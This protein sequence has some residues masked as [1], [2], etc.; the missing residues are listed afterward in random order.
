MSRDSLHTGNGQELAEDSVRTHHAGIPCEGCGAFF[1]PSRP[2][3]RHCRPA[4]RPRA[5]RRR[6]ADRLGDLLDRL[7]PDDPGRPE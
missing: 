4:C 7:L 6:E 1:S 3:Q 2:S 5:Q